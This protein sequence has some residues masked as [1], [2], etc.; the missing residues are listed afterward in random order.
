VAAQAFLREAAIEGATAVACHQLAPELAKRIA[1]VDLVV[2]IDASAGGQPGS[3]T[4]TRLH[5]GA[6]SLTAFSHHV[7]PSGLLVMADHLFGRSPQAFLV[8]VGAGS[9]ELGD[10]LSDAVAAALPHVVATVRH[11]VLRHL[12]QTTSVERQ[13]S[14]ALNPGQTQRRRST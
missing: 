11:L 5:S 7:D 8:A 6:G 12:Q 4:V 13:V 1:T 9:L 2:F 14:C 10:A 3:V